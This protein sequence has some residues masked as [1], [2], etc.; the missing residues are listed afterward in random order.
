MRISSLDSASILLLRKL[1]SLQKISIAQCDIFYIPPH[2]DL[3]D[4]RMKQTV[5]GA[6]KCHI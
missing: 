4:I 6:D 5:I 3:F 2:Y 1:H